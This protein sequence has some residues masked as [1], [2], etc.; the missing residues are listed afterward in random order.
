LDIPTSFCEFWKFEL[1]L[2]ILLNRKE[3]ETRR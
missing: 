1:F 3:N 2:G